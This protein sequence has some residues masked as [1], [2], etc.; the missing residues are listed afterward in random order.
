MSIRID[1]SLP[2]KVDSWEVP[3]TCTKCK[4]KNKVTMGQIKRE[5]TIQCV[6]CGIKINLIDK[7][8]SFQ[9]ATEKIQHELDELERAVRR[10]GR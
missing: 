10:F 3:L 4:T 6:G 2:P 7:D 8:K 1:I 9:K 5:E